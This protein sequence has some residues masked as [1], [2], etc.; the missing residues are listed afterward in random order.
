MKVLILLR[1]CFALCFGV[2][3]YTACIH[4]MS[5]SIVLQCEV[6]V[7]RRPESFVAIYLSSCLS[8]TG[9]AVSCL[10]RLLMFRP[11]EFHS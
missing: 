3:D 2:D 4:W 6:F 7:R 10:L 5:M 1:S 9:L 8:T 11:L